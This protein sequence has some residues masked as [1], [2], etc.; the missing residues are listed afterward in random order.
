[1]IK[2]GINLLKSTAIEAIIPSK[3]LKG[4]NEVLLKD[5]S[6]IP[7]GA[8][9]W[10]AG[11]API[12][13]VENSKF[14]RAGQGRIVV[15]S[16]LRVPEYDRIFAVGDCAVINNNPLPPT[17]NVAEQQG[18]YLVECFNKYYSKVDLNS[19]LT[20]P[21]PVHP[22]AMPLPFLAFL[23]NFFTATSE[24]RYIERGGMVSAGTGGGIADLSKSNLGVPRISLTGFA[25]FVSWRGAYLSKQLSWQNM[26]L[27]PMFWFKSLVFGRD[28]SRF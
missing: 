15:D 23:N 20:N 17:A 25:A 26:M 9:V 8:L 19:K 24:F 3:K 11:L 14:V 4:V 10:S 2:A 5:G 22:Y 16:Y 12:K 7:Y 13:F 1:M 6:C 27:I 28:I 18:A 21:G